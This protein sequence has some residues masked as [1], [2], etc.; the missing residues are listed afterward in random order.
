MA[1]PQIS[2]HRAVQTPGLK[3]LSAEWEIKELPRLYLRRSYDTS[4]NSIGSS[5]S[6]SVSTSLTGYSPPSDHVKETYSKLRS[7]RFVTRM[8]ALQA[9]EVAMEIV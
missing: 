4:G 2:K 8:Q 1:L 7:Q 6:Y 9:L 5:W 3:F